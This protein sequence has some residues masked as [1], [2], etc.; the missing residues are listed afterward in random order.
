MY[1][2]YD[3]FSNQFFVSEYLFFKPPPAY[4]TDTDDVLLGSVDRDRFGV[5]V[6]RCVYARQ[7]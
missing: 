7:K 4:A 3:I 1:Y 6:D 2:F 5:R